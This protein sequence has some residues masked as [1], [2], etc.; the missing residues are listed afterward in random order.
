MRRRGRSSICITILWNRYDRVTRDHDCLSGVI[1]NLTSGETCTKLGL[2]G[3]IALTVLKYAAGIMGRSPAMVADATHSLSDVIATAVVYCSLKIS[4]KPPDEEHPFGHGHAE[5][6][7]AL[8]VGLTL[9]LTGGYIAYGAIISLL[10][11]EYATPG[12]M[13]LVAAVISIIIK[14]FMFR[15]TIYVG[16]KVKS[17]AITANAWD[18]RSDAYSSGAALVGIAGATYGFPYLDPVACLIIAGFIIKV[19]VDIFLENINLVMDVV[20][21]EARRLEEDIKELCLKEKAILNASMVRLRPVGAGKYHA[22]LIINVPAGLSVRKGH[23]VAANIRKKLLV[24][25]SDELIDIMVHVAPGKGYKGVIYKSTPKDLETLILDIVRDCSEA[26]G[27]HDL[28]IFH[29]EKKKLV[30]LDIEVDAG[31][32]IEEAHLVA[33]KIKEEIM[34][35]EDVCSVVIHI[36]HLGSDGVIYNNA[37]A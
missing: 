5:T 26:T 8:F 22:G 13:A 34:R 29:F 3:N 37:L 30:T 16:K 15:Y 6:I 14:E 7:A 28:N 18:H 2:I 23:A 1:M 31:L 27:M 11:G 10:R 32:S 36:D 24:R 33:K 12:P 20:P 17:T 35:L 9:F 25:F 4:S 21:E 19:S